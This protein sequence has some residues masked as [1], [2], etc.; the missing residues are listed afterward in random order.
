MV[1][2]MSEISDGAKRISDIISV[3]DGIAFQTNILALNAAVEAARAGE[4]GRG[5]AVVAAEVRSLAQRSADAAKEIKSLI[6]ASV[7]EVENGTKLVDQAGATISALVGDV[8]KVSGLM[9]SIAEAS[10]EQSRG[11]QQVNK[12]VTE[13]DKVVQQNA[14]AVQA[15]AAAADAMRRQAEALLRAVS[16][17]RLGHDGPAT[18]LAARVS[19]AQAPAHDEAPP[20]AAPQSIARAPRNPPSQPPAAPAP[21][22]ETSDDWEE[23]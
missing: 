8:K 13:M 23:F 21:G 4:Q 3:I 22:R 7:A 14:S 2:T 9:R 12:T 20:V 1:A 17:F 5:V 6:G 10:A 18:A 15:S 11:V 16:T 19:L